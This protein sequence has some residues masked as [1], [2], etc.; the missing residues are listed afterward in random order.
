MALNG[1]FG[2]DTFYISH[3]YCLAYQ[4]YWIT[5]IKQYYHY[6]N[7]DGSALNVSQLLWPHTKYVCVCDGSS[8]IVCVIG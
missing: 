3:N 7:S 1:V 5:S 4:R 8:I 2:M 6:G